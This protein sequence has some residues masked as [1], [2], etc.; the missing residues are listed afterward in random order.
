[1]QFLRR[2]DCWD[3]EFHYEFDRP[4]SIATDHYY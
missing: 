4:T 2:L 3:S 1:M